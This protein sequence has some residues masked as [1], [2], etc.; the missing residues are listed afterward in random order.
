MSYR[1]ELARRMGGRPPVFKTPNDLWRC[2]LEYI[3]MVD[4][5]DI[6]LPTY[7]VKG[8]KR[9]A[10][11]RDNSNKEEGKGG[12]VAR[13]LTFQGF[14]AFTGMGSE[15][16]TFAS[17]TAK[18]SDE[19]SAV[20]S[21]IRAVVQSDQIEGGLANIYN[22]N[23]TARLNGITDRQD[24]TSGGEIIDLKFEIVRSGKGN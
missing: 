23:L 6:N 19:F 12:K 21:R 8:S 15:W 10:K 3:A 7:I 9:G 17:Y 22:S 16:R 24:I 20:I 2:F 14:M 1:S 11:E 5:H 4:A 18:R 13:P